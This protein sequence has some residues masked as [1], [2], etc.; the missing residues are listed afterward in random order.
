MNWMTQ[1]TLITLISGIVIGF[2]LGICQLTVTFNIPNCGRIVGP[3]EDH[4]LWDSDYTSPTPAPTQQQAQAVRVLCW[5]L[6]TPKNHDN[7]AQNVKNTWGSRCNRII[8]VS[9]KEDPELGSIAATQDEGR[10]YLWQK[11]KNAFQYIYQHHLQDAD[12]FFKAD[13][14]TFVIM[15]NL[16][17]MLSE[18]NS[19]LP[20]WLGRR[21]RMYSNQ[22]YMSGGAGYVLSG[23]AVRLLVDK[24]LS[25]PEV[26]RQEHDGDEDVEMGA[27]MQNVGVVYGDSR[28]HEGRER[29]FPYPPS[30]HLVPGKIKRNSWLW[31]WNFYPM[32]VG[33]DCCSPTAISFHYVNPEKMLELEYLVYH[34]VHYHH[35]HQGTA[36]PVTY[37]GTTT[38]QMTHSREHEKK[39]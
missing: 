12:W 5:V 8:F 29:F 39:R 37:N 14:D 32:L 2:L 7:K 19:S 1:K 38:R 33:L 15:E 10:E 16:R 31:G 34:V 28:D 25:N 27:C 24:G 22:G 36:D 18:H 35:H 3:L 17:L 6:T 13:D 9:S 26:C 23:A 20:L 4:P 30:D 11:T 21:S